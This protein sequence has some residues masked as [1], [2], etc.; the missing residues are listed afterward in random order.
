MLSG[1][2]TPEHSTTNLPVAKPSDPKKSAAC[3]TRLSNPPVPWLLHFGNASALHQLLQSSKQVSPAQVTRNIFTFPTWKIQKKEILSVLCLVSSWDL[4]P[5][6]PFLLGV[7]P[8]QHAQPFCSP[9]IPSASSNFKTCRSL[10]QPAS[11]YRRSDDLSSK[12]SRTRPY[13]AINVDLCNIIHHHANLWETTL[14]RGHILGL[15]G[16]WICYDMF[17]EL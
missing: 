12:L 3:P 7:L 1:S 10:L 17:R 5:S 4:P 8:E 15:V 16:R 11:M 14:G 2:A 6:L 13:L 9:T